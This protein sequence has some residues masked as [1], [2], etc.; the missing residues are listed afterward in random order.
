M[1]AGLPAGSIQF[2][3]QFIYW[4]STDT[5]S[6]PGVFAVDRSDRNTLIVVD[7]M[8]TPTFIVPLSPDQQPL[9]GADVDI[10]SCCSA[11]NCS[12]QSCCSCDT[13]S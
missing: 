8:A 7:E 2:G 3:G 6:S 13:A 10:C 9:P 5:S 12:E 1:C 11:V 4:I